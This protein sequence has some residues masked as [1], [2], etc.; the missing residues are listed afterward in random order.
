MEKTMEPYGFYNHWI[1]W[2]MTLVS[3]TNFSILVNGASTKPFYPS[4]VLRQ[5]DPLSP[6]LFLLMME[7]LSRT[8][9]DVTT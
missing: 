5:G 7:G 6:F 1:K 9:K 3:M 4:R 8:I 2:V